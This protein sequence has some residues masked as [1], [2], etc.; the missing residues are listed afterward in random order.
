MKGKGNRRG[1]GNATPKT[2][3]AAP[4]RLTVLALPCAPVAA[5]LDTTRAAP[6]RNL[7]LMPWK[8]NTFIAGPGTPPGGTPRRCP[9]GGGAMSGVYSRPLDLPPLPTSLR[10]L[11]THEDSGLQEA[12]VVNN[13]GLLHLDIYVGH[14]PTHTHS[15]AHSL[16]THPP[17]QKLMSEHIA[18]TVSPLKCTTQ[19]NILYI[20]SF[21]P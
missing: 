2:P 20:N 5:P 17:M 15:T 12:P 14:T 10:V 3:V 11:P 7:V 21:K 1:T 16:D 4:R 18:S 9:F 6:H 8:K 19:R 13:Y